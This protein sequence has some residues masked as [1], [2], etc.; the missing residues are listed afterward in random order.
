MAPLYQLLRK[1]VKW[2]WYKQHATAF[3]TSK[4]ALQDDT[5]LVHYES[6]RP[7]VLACDSSPY[8][9]GAVLLHVMDD[10][11]E[12]PVAYASFTLTAAEKNYSQTGKGSLKSSIWCPEVP[13]LPLWKT[14]HH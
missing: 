9:L 8:G 14:L 4:S 6:M 7:L 2:Q 12:C 5:L 3:A 10:G 1:G 11:Q 13:Q